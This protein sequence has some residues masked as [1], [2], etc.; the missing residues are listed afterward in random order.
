MATRIGDR[1]QPGRADPRAQA[2]PRATRVAAWVAAASFVAGAAGAQ[3]VIGTVVLETT[4]GP[5]VVQLEEANPTVRPYARAFASLVRDRA[6]F[7]RSDKTITCDDENPNCFLCTCV[8]SACQDQPEVSCQEDGF[9]V[10]DQTVPSA[11]LHAGRFAVDGGNHLIEL[12]TV[13]G[14]LDASG[15]F[16]NNAMTVAFVRDPS[17]T[18]T[19]EWVINVAD[20]SELVREDGFTFDDEDMDGERAYFVIGQVQQGQEVVAILAGLTATDARNEE[21]L[22]ADGTSSDILEDLEQLPVIDEYDPTPGPTG[23]PLATFCTPGEADCLEPLCTTIGSDDETCDEPRCY[24]LVPLTPEEEEMEDPPRR[25]AFPETPFFPLIATATPEGLALLNN[26]LAPPESANV[27]DYPNN[28]ILVVD[29]RNAECPPDLSDPRNACANPGDPTDLD[30]RTGGSLAL[31]RVGDTSR[32]TIE[33]G[34]VDALELYE[35]GRARIEGGSVPLLTGQDASDVMLAGGALSEWFADETSTGLVTGG[36]LDEIDAGDTAL[37]RIAGSGFEIGG[38]P[39]PFGPVANLSG[40]L[41]GTLL[42]GDP[43]STAFT[44]GTTATLHLLDAADYT[45]EGPLYRPPD[46][47]DDSPAVLAH[48]TAITSSNAAD[49]ATGLGAVP[50]PFLLSQTEVTNAEYASFLSNIAFSDP[51]GLYNTLMGTDAR[52]GIART[53]T[54]GN[55]RYAAIRGREEQP[56]VFVSLLDTARYVNWLHNGAPRGGGDSVTED[57][58]YAI[59]GTTITRR[60]QARFR[61]PTEDE[62]YKAAYYDPFSSGYSDFPT[63]SATAPAA[64]PPTRDV[65]NAANLVTAL[66]TSPSPLADVGSYRFSGSAYGTLDQ[67]GNVL[68]WVEDSLALRGGAWASTGTASAARQTPTAVANTSVE[69]NDLGFRVVPEP[70]AAALAAAALATLAALGRARRTGPRSAR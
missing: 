36:A 34:A 57:G 63:A 13:L 14:L 26:G 33:D 18:L 4:A 24:A 15:V 65:G 38:N 48:A 31:L 3:A 64:V 60:E 70:S 39:A 44:V 12:P 9:A 8:D 2:A 5:I 42:S 20:N 41:T 35:A 19:T 32:V 46:L 68:E 66:G 59:S 55:Y 7:H 62:W 27:V 54:D 67:A 16:A 69:R 23:D 29:V 25:C 51:H 45:P 21:S 47:P 43:L 61:I 49:P 22:V 6:F 1:S 30:V 53:G 28:P 40:V 10:R 37:V 52:G 58:A 50:Y 17:G 11:V 56:V